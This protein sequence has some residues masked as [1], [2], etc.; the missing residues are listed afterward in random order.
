MKSNKVFLFID[1]SNLY[2][3]QFALFGP[4][5]ILDFKDFI[6]KTE[7]NLKEKYDRIYFYASY[8]PK[9]NKPTKKQKAYLKNE[10]LFYKN[11]RQTPKVEFFKGYRSPTSGKEKEVDV[12]LAVDM[13][14]M[15]HRNEFQKMFLISGD[16][17]F[18][19]ALFAVTKL[20]KGVKLLCVHNKVMYKAM[21]YFPTYII[22]FGDR[23]HIDSNQVKSP[24]KVTIRG[25]SIKI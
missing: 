5:K 24:I 25:K 4:D 11:V 8:S 22:R 6:K 1:G 20:K 7:K 15:A 13:V 18:L 16:A 3:S 21:Y 9:P 17:D 14:D 19:H 10:G 12:K 2:G 23:N